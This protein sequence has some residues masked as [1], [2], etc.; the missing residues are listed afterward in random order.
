MSRDASG[1]ALSVLNSFAGSKIPDQLGIRKIVE[2]IAYKGTKSGFQTVGAVSRQFR[3]ISKKINP[4][5][6]SSTKLGKNQELFDLSISE[7]QQMVRDSV[8]R[9]AANVI[10]PAAAQANEDA[11]TPQAVL[12]QA[13]ELGLI[14]YAIPES[15]GGASVERST[16][17]NMLITEDLAHGDMGIAVA[18]LSP[19]SVANALTQWG[20]GA[21]QEKYLAAF[22]DENKP[23]QASIAVNEP[24][25]LFNP[26]K[27][28]T[29][30]VKK[31]TQYILNGVKT[32]VPIASQSELF[33]VAADILGSGP[34]IFIIESSSNGLT[35]ENDPSMGIKAANIGKLTLE[36]VSIDESQLLGENNSEF[37][38]AEFIEYSHISW[39]A[40]AV[41]CGQAVLDYVIPYCNERFAF[42]EPISHR[43]S[44]AFMVANIGIELDAMRL[45]TMRAANR[46]ERGL[47]FKKQSYLARVICADKSMEIGT[48]G[49]Q[50]LGGHGFTKE[51]PVERWYRDMRII[52]LSEGGLHL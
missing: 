38:F 32:L 5:R 16:I 10:R 35:I 41:G 37:N 12:D 28:N 13:A 49:V 30:A 50:L 4:Q 24:T 15:M 18:I 22:L 48:N 52:S 47:D 17:T 8:Q 34:G 26:H 3:N 36:N 27:L 43:Q 29:K 31:G 2:K 46:A 7:E 42:G 14:Y 51:Y 6:L 19:I 11:Q 20:S 40:A 21:Q 39:C 45:M 25:A 23:L 9:F 33:L 44:V 1:L